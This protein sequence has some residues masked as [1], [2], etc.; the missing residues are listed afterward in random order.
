MQHLVGIEFDGYDFSEIAN[1][2]RMMFASCGYQEVPMKEMV[3]VEGH[4]DEGLLV[5]ASGMD[6]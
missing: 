1:G 4:C 3:T 6:N 5:W 2:L